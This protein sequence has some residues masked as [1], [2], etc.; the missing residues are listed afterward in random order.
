MI[1]CFIGIFVTSYFLANLKTAA[2]ANL[3]IKQNLDKYTTVEKDEHI[4]VDFDELKKINS[5]TVGYI[6]VPNTN[7]DYVVVK[8]KN[9]DYYLKHNF[10]KK[11]NIAGWIFADYRN[12]IDGEDNNLIIYGHETHDGSMFGSLS[13]LLEEDSINNNNLVINFITTSG[14]K[15]YQVFSI[16]TI[17]PEEHYI[18]T[19]FKK[20]EFEEFKKEMKERSKYKVDIDISDKNII[21]L[22]TCA[23]HGAK[24]LVVHAIEI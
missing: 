13:N 12:R 5:D 17:K 16:Y 6:N 24:R 14:A 15:Q 9:N 4:N 19:E 8:G 20:N 7:V 21:T 3:D 11:K 10:N 22:S 1:I 23:N 18:T 2:K